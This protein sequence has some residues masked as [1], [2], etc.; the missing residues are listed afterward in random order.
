MAAEEELERIKHLR[1]IDEE[2]AVKK[3]LDCQINDASRK[4]QFLRDMRSRLSKRNEELDAEMKEVEAENDRLSEEFMEPPMKDDMRGSFFDQL[5]NIEAIQEH[6]RGQIQGLKVVKHSLLSE[7]NKTQNLVKISRAKIDELEQQLSNAEDEARTRAGNL[8]AARNKL[9]ELDNE[10]ELLTDQCATIKE[11]I[12][13]KS[14]ELRN[15]SQESIAT[16]ISQKKAL[17]EELKIKK[18][19]RKKLKRSAKDYEIKS[20]AENKIRSKK[21]AIQS[22]PNVWMSQ[23]LSLVSK[24]KKARDEL[25]LLENRQRGVLKSNSRNDTIREVNNW[26]DETA[27][28]CIACEIAELQKEPPKFLMNSLNTELAFKK[29]MEAQ[30]ADIEK[31]TAH[32]GEFKV[33]TMQLMHEQ[34]IIAGQAERLALLKKELSE[35]RSKI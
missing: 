23:R 25:D 2:E 10:L 35:L 9:S 24:V 14:Q 20:Q 7:T 15:V 31:T 13:N 12:K 17:E 4:L 26:N 6:L 30:L 11:T 16:L 22:S 27:K 3:L 34:E 8:Q 21:Q 33:N 18:Q 19:E 5:R 29:E 1:A 32:I 28:Y